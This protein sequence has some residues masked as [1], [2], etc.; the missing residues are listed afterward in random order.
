MDLER[1][2]IG[3]WAD[4]IPYRNANS[5]TKLPAGKKLTRHLF[6]KIIA[7]KAICLEKV[8]SV[9]LQLYKRE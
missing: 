2:A 1:L 7:K 5:V 6:D 9:L 4:N 8:Q 3:R